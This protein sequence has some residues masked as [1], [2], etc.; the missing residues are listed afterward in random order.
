MTVTVGTEDARRN[1][2]VNFVTDF[3]GMVNRC[4]NQQ[5][6]RK[7]RGQGEGQEMLLLTF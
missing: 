3:L 7:G 2:A 1:I 4:S 6:R 5:E